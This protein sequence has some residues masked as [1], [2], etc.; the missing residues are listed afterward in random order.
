MKSVLTFLLSVII[1][2]FLGL[3]LKCLW[4]GEIILVLGFIFL[5]L[6]LLVIL[7]CIFGGEK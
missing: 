5:W 2:L 7:S 1:G 3:V 4:N 6:I